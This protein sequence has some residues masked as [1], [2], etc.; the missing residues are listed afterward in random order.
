[1][2]AVEAWV[3]MHIIGWKMF[4]SKHVSHYQGF[5]TQTGPY[6]PTGKPRTAHFYGSFSIKNRPREKKVGNRANH[7]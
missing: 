3:F 7:G 5:E 2:G 4:D 6:G 1:M